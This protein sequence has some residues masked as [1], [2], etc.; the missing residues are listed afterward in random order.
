MTQNEEE[1]II[2]RRKETLYQDELPLMGAAEAAMALGVKQSNLRELSG[3][4]KA[5]QTLACGSIWLTKDIVAFREW[6]RA[7]PPRPGP[8]PKKRGEGVAA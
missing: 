7:N 5:F 2:A 4:P 6:R 1:A 8:K 3:L